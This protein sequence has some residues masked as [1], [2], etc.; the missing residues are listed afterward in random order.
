MRCLKALTYVSCV[1]LGFSQATAAEPLTAKVGG[2]AMFYGSHTS[3]DHDAGTRSSDFNTNIEVYIK[4]EGKLESGLK[5]GV[6]LEL[7]ADQNSTSNEDENFLY[8]EH[9]WGRVELGQKEGVTTYDRMMTGA[10]SDFASGGINGRNSDKFSDYVANVDASGSEGLPSALT[11]LYETF[12]GQDS[13]KISYFSP[14]FD[15]FQFGASYTPN[16]AEEGQSTV[17]T[18]GAA[19]PTN[20]LSLGNFGDIL[21]FGGTYETQFNDA[22]FLITAGYV[23]GAVDRDT[24]G[25]HHEDLRSWTIGSQISIGNFTIGAGYVTHGDSGLDKAAAYRDDTE[26]YTAGI[27]YEQDNWIIGTNYLNAQWEDDL[28]TAQNEKL[29]AHSIGGTYFVTN[30]FSIFSEMTFFDFEGDYASDT[31][32]QSTDGSVFLA[33]TALKF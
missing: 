26:G 19:L 5:Y 28:T 27:Q 32:R 11:G 23:T 6:K 22:G 3:E 13:T 25:A 4:A 17:R 18:N 7:E 16:G 10:P 15:G 12:S 31:I 33:G 29:T 20:A 14:K 1:L 8:A 24:G 9:T 30:H 21:E 2:N